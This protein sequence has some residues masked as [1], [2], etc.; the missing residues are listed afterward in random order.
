MKS[1]KNHI[2]FEHGRKSKIHINFEH[3]KYPKSTITLNM[4]ILK[5][6]INFENVFL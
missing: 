6:L 4:N 3:E 1:S 2:N 5:N